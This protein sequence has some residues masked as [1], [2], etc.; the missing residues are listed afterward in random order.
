M[1]CILQLNN[2]SITGDCSNT[3]SGE[4]TIQVVSLSPG[5]TAVWSSPPYPTDNF[6]FVSPGIYELTKTGLSAG[7]YSFT[8]ID[9]CIDPEPLQIPYNIYISS[10]TCVSIDAVQNTVCGLNNG[11]ITASTSSI[12]G[13]EAK[14]YLYETTSGYVTSATSFTNVTSDFNSLPPGTYYVIGDDGGGCTGMSETCII[15]SSTTFDYDFYIVSNAACLPSNSAGAVYI[16]NLNGTPPYTYSWNTVP[17]QTTSY[18]TGLTEGFYQVTVTDFSGCELTKTA[19]V[20]IVPPLGLGAIYTTSPSCF[21]NDAQVQIVVTG[22]TPPYYYSGSNGNSVVSFGSTYTFT[23]VAPGP[24]QIS[25]TDAGLCNII[26]G[27]T[28]TNPLGFAN[29]VITTVNSTCTN[30]DG[31]IFI[32]VNYLT[33]SFVIYTLTNS[34]NNVTT[35]NIVQ[36]PSWNFTNLE[37][38]TYTLTISGGSCVYTTTVTINNTALIETDYNVTGTTCGLNNGAIELTVSG[39]VGPYSY[40]LTGQL[41]INNSA[42]SSQT[43]TN[44]ASG[45]YT[46]TITDVGSNCSSVENIFVPPSQNANASMFSTQPSSYFYDGSIT[47]LITSGTPPFTWTWSPNVNGQTGLTVNNL[48]GGTYTFILQDSLGCTKKRTVVLNKY[49]PFSSYQTYNICD[50]NFQNTGILLT[51]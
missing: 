32:T 8:I 47:A 18:I 51:K 49:T 45:N 1:S 2:V 37:S 16:T 19:N 15:K 41:G 39:G 13:T 43:F 9:S 5:V 30:N 26:A 34:S 29:A 31:I 38:D 14:F 21:G 25:V 17:V 3:N 36:S 40:T 10:G 22:G 23:N 6:I 33:S 28:L 20:G 12:Y 4:F 44:L 46:A 50:S 27:T 35:S 42:F 7:T 11:I 48:S 24:F